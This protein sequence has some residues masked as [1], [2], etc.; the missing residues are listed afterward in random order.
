MFK[1]KKWCSN[2]FYYLKPLLLVRSWWKNVSK[3][4]IKK[5]IC[6]TFV[7]VM[8]NW[9]SACAVKGWKFEP[10]YTDNPSYQR[11]SLRGI[12]RG[13]LGQKFRRLSRKS[14]TKSFYTLDKFC[15][16]YVFFFHFFIRFFTF[17]PSNGLEF[18]MIEVNGPR[19]RN[20]RP[21]KP[22]YVFF[23]IFLTDFFQF[24]LQMTLNLYDGG[25]R[26]SDSKLATPTTYIYI[27]LDFF[28]WFFSQ[29]H[30]IEAMNFSFF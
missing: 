7:E 11:R 5:L 13:S 24:D 12:K 20:Q 16:I 14:E 1:I 17:W 9:V 21:Q 22:M 28:Y 29:K 8:V 26:T 18:D 2:N 4:S 25:Q 6:I 15:P 30:C 10:L 3:T 23:W 27:F 19:I